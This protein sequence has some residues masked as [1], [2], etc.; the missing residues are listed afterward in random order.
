MCFFWKFVLIE[1]RLFEQIVEV[2][3]FLQDLFEFH[4]KLLLFILLHAFY[5]LCVV[6]RTLWFAAILEIV[7]FLSQG[8]DLLIF[9]FH[10]V[11]KL[12]EGVLVVADEIFDDASFGHWLLSWDLVVCWVLFSWSYWASVMVL[13]DEGIEL[14][15]VYVAE[16]SVESLLFSWLGSVSFWSWTRIPFVFS[17]LRPLILIMLPGLWTPLYTVSTFIWLISQW[18]IVLLCRRSSSFI[19]IFNRNN[20]MSLVH[21]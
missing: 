17:R 11:F 15:V 1:L 9:C 19:L 21:F 6:L 5:F 7:D 10:F 8:F 2:V 13:S 3:V 20:F 12:I 14:F 18:L 4:L 16:I